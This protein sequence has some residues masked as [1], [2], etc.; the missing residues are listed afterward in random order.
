[1]SRAF[2]LVAKVF[3]L[4]GNHRVKSVRRWDLVCIDN[5]KKKERKEG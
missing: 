4:I 3:M 1:M 2:N 5:I